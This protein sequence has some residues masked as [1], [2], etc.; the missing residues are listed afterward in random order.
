M[1]LSVKTEDAATGLV[2]MRP[3]VTIYGAI[4]LLVVGSASVRADPEVQGI[5]LATGIVVIASILAD[6]P[7]RE[8]PDSIHFEVGRFDPVKNVKQ[9]TAFGIEYH[10]DRLVWWGLRPFVGAG[11]TSDRSAWGYGGIRYA[12]NW[13]EH[14][15]VTPSFAIGGYGRG[16]G[17]DLG[18]PPVVGRFGID[19]EYRFDNGMRI[20]AAYQH[21][22]NGKV[23]HQTNNPGT[24]VIG[25]T[26]S[27]PIR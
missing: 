19:F 8:E 22:S 9:A 1:S 21:M 2:A 13:G 12:T 15:A 5:A 20:G 6:M 10:V 3:F 18:Q 16:Q 27:L 4:V 26:F 25:A 24:E 14:T 17:K 23:L 7:Q 11:F